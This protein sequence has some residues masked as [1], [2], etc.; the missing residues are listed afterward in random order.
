MQSAGHGATP[1]ASISQSPPNS[2]HRTEITVPMNIQTL[3][4]HAAQ[5]YDRTRKQYIPCL[6]EFYG[7]VLALLPFDEQAE[8]EIL[9][10]VAVD[11]TD[12]KNNSGTAIR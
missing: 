11:C 7:T 3:F 10:V 2:H 9:Q 4:D 5:D 1:S 8:I 6:H 12:E